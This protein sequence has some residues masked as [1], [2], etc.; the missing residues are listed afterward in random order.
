[1]EDNRRTALQFQLRDILWCLV[2]LAVL[3]GWW[4]SKPAPAPPP[5]PPPAGRFTLEKD[6]NI[7]LFFD[8]AT[9]RAW[10]RSEGIWRPLDT[11]PSLSTLGKDK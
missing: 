10:I 6:G 4:T 1:M 11:P 8:T 2:V 9:G 5:E 7:Y 3:F